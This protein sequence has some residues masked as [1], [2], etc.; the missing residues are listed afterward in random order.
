MTITRYFPEVAST[1]FSCQFRGMRAHENGDWVKFSEV[2]RLRA[3]LKLAAETLW[4]CRK[5]KLAGAERGYVYAAKRA[6]EA[7]G[8]V[9]QEVI[10]ATRD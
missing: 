8:E 3:A 2:E 4:G 10:E 7:A 9:P 5:F 1:D 6:Y